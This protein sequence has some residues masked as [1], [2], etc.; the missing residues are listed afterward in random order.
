MQPPSIHLWIQH[1]TESLAGFLSASVVTTSIA[2]SL[3]NF[4][5][6]L[7][8]TIIIAFA[9][10]AVGAWAGHLVKKYLTKK[11]NEKNNSK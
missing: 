5:V 10:G 8:Q 7:I 4:A 6:G 2:T 9:S 11:E 3:T 1:H